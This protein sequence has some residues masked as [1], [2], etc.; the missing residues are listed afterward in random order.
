MKKDFETFYN[1]LDKSG[2]EELWNKALEE[3]KKRNRKALLAILIIDVIILAIGI[4]FKGAESIKLLII[5]IL[6]IDF[7]VVGFV[8]IIFS[9]FFS[10]KTKLYDEQYKEKVVDL[11]IKNFFN[12][13]DYVP[14]KGMSREIYNSV[15]YR[16]SYDRYSSDDYID[17][18]IDDKYKIKMADITTEEEHTSTDSDGH[19]TT[20]YVTVF[21][22]LFAQIDMGKSINN[23]L[24]IRT[25][26]SIAK[27]KRVNMDSQEFEKYFDVSSTDKIVAMQLLTHDI[28]DLLLGM[29]RVLDRNFDIII[30]NNIMY[31]RLH[32]GSLFG[33]NLN[34]KDIID[35]NT[36]KRYFD[37]LDFIYALS[38]Q[39]IKLVEET[40]I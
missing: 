17:A 37:I 14:E 16:E 13:V 23:R 2:L 5:P 24:E 27:K 3:K 39:M 12:N 28:M 25:N 35:K 6:F 7:Y 11:M 34:K 1:E 20:T 40:Q 19:T 22:G 18:Y 8:I 9:L 31:I 29:R 30:I 4:W 32:V 10:K 26:R 36:T 38:K 15:K 33:A 21:S